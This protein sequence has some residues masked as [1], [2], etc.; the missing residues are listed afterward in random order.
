MPHKN[1]VIF[2]GHLGSDANMKFTPSG[3]AITESTLA[4]SRSK[5]NDKGE[6]TEEKPMWLNVKWLGKSAEKF[7][8]LPK[9]SGVIIFGRLDIEEW[10][11]DDKTYNNG[12]AIR[13][14]KTVVIANETYVIPKKEDGQSNQDSPNADNDIPF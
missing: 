2:A 12:K 7:A 10:E 14:Q 4:V 11:L 8:T 3:F 6:W 9:G 13:Q 5:R 1:Q